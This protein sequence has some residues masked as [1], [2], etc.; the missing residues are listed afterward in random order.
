[1]IRCSR[2]GCKRPAEKRSLCSAHYKAERIARSA[3][4]TVAA[5]NNRQYARGICIMHYA[6]VLRHGDVERCKQHP[7]L[8]FLNGAIRAN[9]DEC[10]EWPFQIIAG[11]GVIEIGGVRRL[12]HRLVC[13]EAHGPPPQ[14][15]SHAAH[16]PLICSNRACINP[17]HLRWATP[18]ENEADKVIDGTK[19]VGERIGI[20]KLTELDVIE[21]RRSSKNLSQ[22]SREYGV[23]RQAV[24][25]VKR[26]E[27]WRHVDDGKVVP[28]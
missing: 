20:S 22:L 17:R 11:Y 13:E 15:N 7:A 24:R 18:T 19:A 3:P 12:A 23:S 21:I 9:L 16:A 10:I 1:M 5:C 14:Q 8:D 28:R 4:C 27:T 26:Y 6:R 25:S 2:N